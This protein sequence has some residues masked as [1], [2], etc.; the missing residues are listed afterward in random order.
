M[1]MRD[2]GVRPYVLGAIFFSLPNV[3]ADAKTRDEDWQYRNGEEVSH[4]VDFDADELSDAD[5]GVLEDALKF[6]GMTIGC[7][8]EY[9]LRDDFSI[10]GEY[11]IRLMFDGAEREER[12]D[13]GWL[14]EE[15]E[16][17]VGVTYAAVVVGYHF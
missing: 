7:G 17:V 16:A 14:R 12:D 9:F 4:D 13:D 15:A 3:S 8:G 2:Q 5:K 11:G 6:W 1:Y 10:A